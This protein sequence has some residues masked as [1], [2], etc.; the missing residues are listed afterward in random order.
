MFTRFRGVGTLTIF[1]YQ[2]VDE[3][4]NPID[5][6]IFEILT[7]G[8]CSRIM[9]IG[10]KNLGETLNSVKVKSEFLEAEDLDPI[11]WYK[12]TVIS[13]FLSLNGH[14]WQSEII[15]SLE[16]DS[17]VFFFMKWQP[18]SM[19]L[20]KIDIKWSL[21]AETNLNQEIRDLCS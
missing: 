16:A 2:F 4:G 15:F 13:T 5:K 6:R 18:T 12:D 11:I 7:G 8:D 1:A 9:K 19:S 17:T 14:D 3:F 10:L 20:P 21:V